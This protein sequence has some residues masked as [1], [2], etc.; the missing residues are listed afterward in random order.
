[1]HMFIRPRFALKSLMLFSCLLAA[2]AAHGETWE[3]I[4]DNAYAT[5][6]WEDMQYWKSVEGGTNGLAGVAPSAA[7]DFIVHN[8]KALRSGNPNKFTTNN[9]LLMNFGGNSLQIGDDSTT[10]RFTMDPCTARFDRVGLILR[11]GNLYSNYS[12][13]SKWY[14]DGRV[15]VTAPVDAPFY[16]CSQQA[17]YSN[18]TLVIRA[19]LNGASGTGLRIGGASRSIQPPQTTFVFAN[20]SGYKG[21]VFVANDKFA[22]NGAN[23]G[24]KALFGTMATT[25]SITVEPGGCFGAYTA[26]SIVSASNVSFASGSRLQVENRGSLVKAT[27]TLTVAE[28][29]QVCVTPTFGDTQ[30]YIRWPI[31]QGPADSAFTESTFT[32]VQMRTCNNRDLALDV[33]TD[34][35]ADTKTLYLSMKAGL[36]TQVLSLSNE[37]SKDRGT[38]YFGSSM[39]NR[40]SWS[41]GELPHPGSDYYSVRA[42]RTPIMTSGSPAV[43]RFL[44]DSLTLDSGATFTAFANQVEIPQLTLKGTAAV[45]SGQVGWNPRFVVT[46]GVEVADSPLIAAYASQRLTFA[47]EISGTAVLRCVGVD[48]TGSPTGYYAFEALNTNFLGTVVVSQRVASAT[49]RPLLYLFD[50]R[51]LGGNLPA[52]N[53]RALQL[54]VRA[55]V[56][57]TN[58]DRV[59]TLAGDL[60]RGVFIG[61]C[62]GFY[63]NHSKAVIEVRQPI[64][65]D[66]KMQIEGAGR[67]VLGGEMTFAAADGSVSATP[68]AKSNLVSM[69]ANTTLV[70]AHSSCLDGCA[71][72]MAANT[73][74]VLRVDLDDDDLTRQGIRLTKDGTSLSLDSSF[75]GK[76]PLS[77]ETSS[78]L[79]HSATVGLVTVPTGSAIET[80]VLAAL[81]ESFPKLWPMTRQK[82]ITVV[83]AESGL[84]TIALR[85]TPV[86]TSLYLR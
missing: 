31:L 53:P 35:E 59:V 17:G 18:N 62:G 23:W 45:V 41:D 55:G 78:E 46:G 70:A 13:G 60:N 12:V 20:P 79:T 83:D 43:F 34:T 72:S 26:G 63:P 30:A 50:G 57:V 84:T 61:G 39:T 80:A 32:L 25:D 11:N 24:C 64:L 76:L 42:L 19:E 6:A 8:S 81:P 7:D 75:G 36:V 22:N 27:S 4:T 29:T 85:V 73:K 65:L 14:V 77:L 10:G 49:V 86:G 52:F 33:V 51:N 54:Y 71:L 16:I 38:P 67:T 74:L 68:R 2:V 28:G 15:T 37:G 66:G 21:S 82:L 69:A 1:M 56:C 9:K 48:N 40:A 47:S 5:I 58:T 44:G 3:L